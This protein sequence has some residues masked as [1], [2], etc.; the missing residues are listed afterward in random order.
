[1]KV[2]VG[3]NESCLCNLFFKRKCC[4]ILIFGGEKF[5]KDGIK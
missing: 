1:M 2:Y 3:G 5:E 4:R